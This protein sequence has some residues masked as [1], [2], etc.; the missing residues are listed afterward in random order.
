MTQ[1]D[2]KSHL[3]LQ[4]A[5]DQRPSK[6]AKLGEFSKNDLFSLR[7]HAHCSREE[8]KIATH[9]TENSSLTARSEHTTGMC[10]RSASAVLFLPQAPTLVL[11]LRELLCLSSAF[12]A[13]APPV[14]CLCETCRGLCI[15]RSTKFIAEFG[16][17]CY[18]CEKFIAD[19]RWAFVAMGSFLFWLLIVYQP[20]VI[21]DSIHFLRY[22]TFY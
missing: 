20:S 3:P 6:T 16:R 18:V 14:V 4:P 7:S 9:W 22:V 1:R 12:P 11:Y 21:I 19:G 15:C 8:T 17:K 10:K 2:Q 13:S 5:D